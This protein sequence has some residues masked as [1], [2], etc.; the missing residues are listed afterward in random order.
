MRRGATISGAIHGAVILA[1]A[2][3]FDWFG[4]EAGPQ[5]VVSDV[6]LIDAAAFDAQLSEAPAP[7][8]DAPDALAIPGADA[9]P[10]AVEAPND[11]TA[12]EDVAALLVAPAPEARPDRPVIAGPP[13]PTTV[14]TEA[15]RPSIAEIPSPD[16][17]PRQAAAPESP[18]ST[19]PL[20]PLASAE[21]ALPGPTPAR[22]PDPEPEPLAAE[23]VVEPAEAEETVPVDPEA[24]AETQPEGE[25][26]A[27]PQ[28]ARLPVARPAEL[29][30]AAQASQATRQPERAAE[31]TAQAQPEPV[32]EA[33][34]PQGSAP[35]RFAAIVTPGER[36]ALS[37]GIRQYF[38]FNGNRTDPALSVTIA[39]ELNQ[40]G[41]IVS[42]PS[43]VSDAGEPASARK[44]LFDSGR[45]ALIRAWRQGGEFAKLPIAKYDAWRRIHVTFTPENIGFAS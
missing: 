24:L 15:P 11:A 12:R 41:D 7:P 33:T 21:A 29:A 37:V 39:I 2:I 45:R 38:V 36:E 17:M 31:E 1:A 28:E 34:A 14:P 20:Q 43:L 13:P 22:P 23:E 5:I 6:T 32:D 44:Q 4:A 8:S 42:G 27:A 10:Q 26:A 35:S 3:G 25:I 16:A 40:A 9:A 19:E 18:P 30:A